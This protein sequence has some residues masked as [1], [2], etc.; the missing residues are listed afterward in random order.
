MM[1]LVDL[2]LLRGEKH[3]FE[4]KH[5]FSVR[6]FL[7]TSDAHW[8]RQDIQCVSKCLNVCERSS[9]RNEMCHWCSCKNAQH[10][11]VQTLMLTRFPLAFQGQTSQAD[12]RSAMPE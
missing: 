8:S 6:G 2:Q 9:Y 3:A 10:G 4:A 5:R 11:M 12:S 1:K 7:S